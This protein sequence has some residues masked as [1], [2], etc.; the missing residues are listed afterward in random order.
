[1]TEI[2]DRQQ[3]LQRTIERSFDNFKKI[4]RNN[5]TAAKIRTRIQSLKEAWMEFQSGHIA[6]RRAI[7]TSDPV[8]LAYFKKNVYDRIEEIFIST[9]DYMSE[10]LEEVEPHVSFNESTEQR[11]NRPYELLSLSNLPSINLSP[12]DG[13]YEQWEPFRDRF[14]CLIINN[15]DL[16][17]FARMHYLT[18]CLKGKALEC[19]NN[20][21]VTADSFCDAWKKLMIR[22]EN[23]R[24]LLNKHMSVL[25][26]LAAIPRES[27]DD[28]QSLCDKLNNVVA[29]LKNLN[30][31]PEQLWDDILVHIVAQK[32]DPA[33]R[34]VWNLKS[35]D[36][37]EPSSFDEL[38]Q[39][40]ISRTRGLEN[41]KHSNSP[42]DKLPAKFSNVNK[43]N[44]T[45]AVAN[46][47]SKCL[48]CNSKHF[49]NSCPNFLSMSPSQR[50]DLIKRV[51][52]CF[53]CLS[54]NHSGTEC[55]SKYTCRICRKKHHTLL[56][57]G[58]D[59][60][61]AA[62]LDSPTTNSTDNSDDSKHAVL[63]L[64][65]S[66]KAKPRSHVLLATAWI[67]VSVQSG[68]SI[69][70]RALL[71]QGSEMTFITE[72]LAQLLRVKRIR[73]PTEISAVGYISFGTY[74]HAAQIIISPRDAST[75]EFATRAFI[76][77]T[78]TAYVPRRMAND[79]ALEHLTDVP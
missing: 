54:K 73:M 52:R 22:F 77:K 49:I 60:F 31:A 2:M 53:N 3:Q 61:S 35:S 55:K 50:R 9:L 39:F 67:R 72:N 64:C 71:D 16:S 59:S 75:P 33:T 79:S 41:F 78:L 25:L 7:P 65:S 1:M 15:P 74:Q 45:S 56:H 36:D 18:S 69:N 13:N 68:R 63:S 11:R 12:F 19:I 24:R 51:N 26:N 23:K 40:L 42:H 32:L 76:L 46:P 58:S 38:N 21:P 34:K 27:A 4:G 5:H 62:E 44:S 57:V 66:A 47:S 8:T 20:L 14:T 70:V 43:V 29:S 28:L 6:L 10:C 48:L 17:N 30:R 37:A